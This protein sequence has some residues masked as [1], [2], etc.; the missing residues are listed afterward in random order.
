MSCWQKADAVSSRK[1]KS[2]LLEIWDYALAFFLHRLCNVL[3]K[4]LQVVALRRFVDCSG[5]T[6]VRG[7]LV[8]AASLV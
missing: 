5:L 8:Q 7:K 6:S 2:K 4:L 1:S 3:G